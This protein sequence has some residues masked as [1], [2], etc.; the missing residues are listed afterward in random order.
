M[1]RPSPGHRVLVRTAS[2]GSWCRDDGGGLNGFN[3]GFIG[4]KSE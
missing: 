3:A 4:S 2:E 1:T